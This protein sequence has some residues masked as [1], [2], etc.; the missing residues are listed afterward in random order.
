MIRHL[1]HVRRQGA[2]SARS[3]RGNKRYLEGIFKVF[4]FPCTEF[5]R[6]RGKDPWRLQHQV[7]IV[8]AGKDASWRAAELT[9]FR[10]GPMNRTK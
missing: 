10:V 5:L 3:S 9:H 8:M 6:R 7:L 1:R 2:Q 4:A